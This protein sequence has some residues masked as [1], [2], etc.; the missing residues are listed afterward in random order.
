MTT[1]DFALRYSQQRQ[2]IVGVTYFLLPLR[3]GKINF[4]KLREKLEGRMDLDELY[5]EEITKDVQ[6]GEE[7]YVP[8]VFKEEEER[9]LIKTTVDKV[10]LTPSSLFGK[11]TMDRPHSLEY[12]GY[13]ILVIETIEVDFLIFHDDRTSKYYLVI[14][15]SRANSKNLFVSLNSFLEKIGLFAVPSKLDPDKIDLVREDLKGQ[16]IDTTLNQF[17]SPKIKMKRIIGR[18]YQDEPS[19]LQDA[20]LGSVHQHMFE[21]RGRKNA[22]PRVITLSEDGL[23]RFYTAI[24][25]NDYE[26][27]LRD[28]ILPSL[29]QIKKLPIAPISAYTT[30][31][32]VFQE[33]EK[34]EN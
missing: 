30:L 5:E 10:I 24:T 13:R 23:V 16:L 7:I 27:F 22:P 20:S 11:A 1:P 15:G 34:G 32:D 28:H 25:Y 31:D 26:W 33:E 19:Y 18:G 12:R 8:D 21:Y 2:P 3:K 29:R 17:P 6:E 14:L 4:V 9:I